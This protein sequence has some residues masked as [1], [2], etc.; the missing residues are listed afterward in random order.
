MLCFYANSDP[1]KYRFCVGYL[2]C[3]TGIRVGLPQRETLPQTRH[4]DGFIGLS[5]W[6]I[7]AGSHDS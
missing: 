6:R 3:A 4:Q 5:F 7:V 2:A 1:R